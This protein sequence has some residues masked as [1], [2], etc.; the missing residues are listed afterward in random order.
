MDSLANLPINVVDLAVAVVLLLSAGLAFVRGFVKEVL[1]VAGWIG[2]AFATL[3]LLPLVEPLAKQYIPMSAPVPSIAAMVALF[4]LALV[5]FSFLAHALARRVR[6]ST[7]NALDRSL[8]FLFG[9]LRGAVVVCIAY[10]LVEMF[11]PQ[12]E[13][14]PWLR[15]ARVMPIARTGKNMLC[16]LVP[17]KYREQCQ[18]PDAA[19]SPSSAAGE[20]SGFLPKVLDKARDSDD[21]TGYKRSPRKQLDQLIRSNQ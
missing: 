1:G 11:L 4:L 8:G 10:L 12:T 6:D 14:P 19:G 13:H 3:Y 18:S 17:R 15:E 2:A 5:L 9:L 21:E 7:L 16:T 20:E